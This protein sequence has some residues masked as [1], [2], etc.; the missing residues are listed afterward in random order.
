MLSVDV[1]P[2][3]L[4]GWCVLVDGE[5]VAASYH[6][7]SWDAEN[8]ASALVASQGSGEIRICDES[9]GVQ[10]VKRWSADGDGA[11][12]P[13]LEW[14][15]PCVSG[16]WPAERLRPLT[17]MPR[18][19]ADVLVVEVEGELDL[20]T[21]PELVEALRDP[22]DVNGVVVDLLLLN[23]MDSSGLH[24]LIAAQRRLEADGRQLS[25]LCPEGAVRKILKLTGAEMVLNV[26]GEM[27][28]ALAVAG[29]HRA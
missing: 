23:F 1:R 29:D 8:A 6:Q 27:Q 11:S 25:I 19:V 17:V 14:E 15:P 28:E 20:S 21:V 24:A 2:S 12:G 10:S 5:A 7:T 26:C 3:P 9:G 22:G 13:A 18:R 4:G 16:P